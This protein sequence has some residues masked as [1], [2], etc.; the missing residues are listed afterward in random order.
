MGTPFLTRHRP[1]EL[2]WNEV[3]W[4]HTSKDGRV[5]AT[6]IP[7]H[8]HRIYV[9]PLASIPMG[10]NKVPERGNVVGTLLILHSL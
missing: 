9:D 3:S 1:H 5:L 7:K 8:E 6:V 10:G 2:M 4:N